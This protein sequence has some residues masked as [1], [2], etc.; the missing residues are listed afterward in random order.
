MSDVRFYCHF[1]AT[2]R[3]VGPVTSSVVV[4]W[5]ISSLGDFLLVSFHWSCHSTIF[6]GALHSVIQCSICPQLSHGQGS[7][8]LSHWGDRSLSLLFSSSLCDRNRILLYS[9]RSTCCPVSMMSAS[10]VVLLSQLGSLA[11]TPFRISGSTCWRYKSSE[12]S[13]ET[14]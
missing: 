13:S 7:L 9:S 2:H 1:L 6:H 14:G 5:E 4:V 8:G 3:T 12:A 10:V 11:F